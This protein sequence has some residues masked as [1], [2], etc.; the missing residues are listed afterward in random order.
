MLLYTN[1]PSLGQIQTLAL[2]FT[3]IGVLTPLETPLTN[4]GQKLA[5]KHESLR[6]I[7]DNSIVAKTL[8]I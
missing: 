5:I 3:K 6:D 4:V 7:K 8:L 1:I 2:Q